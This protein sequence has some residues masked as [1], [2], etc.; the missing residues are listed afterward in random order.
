MRAD[1]GQSLFKGETEVITSKSYYI[2]ALVLSALSERPVRLFGENDSNDV[3]ATISAIQTLGAKVKKT[4]NGYIVIPVKDW[5]ET[6][7]ISVGESATLLRVLT[8]VLAAKGVTAEVFADGSLKTRPVNSLIRPLSDHGI[9][10]TRKTFPIS[11]SGRLTAGRYVITD[12]TTSGV[13]SGLITALPILDGDSAIVADINSFNKGYID[14]TLSAVTDFG[15]AITTT[16]T[17]IG[18][19]GKTQYGVDEYVVEKDWSNGAVWLVAGALSGNVTVRGLNLSSA[20]Y[21][22]MIVEYLSAMGAEISMQSGGITVRKSSLLPI[23]R[24]MKRNLDIVP[25]LAVAC[26]AADGISVLKNIERLTLKESDRITEIMRLLAAL[27]VKTEYKDGDLT[28]YGGYMAAN[29]AYVA[30][31]DHRIVMA[32][33]IAGAVTGLTVDGVEAVNKS[34]PQFFDDYMRLGGDVTICQ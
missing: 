21:D 9:V 28:V 32:A 24:D 26:A 18:I 17:G 6:V 5:P 4:R 22:R 34:Y 3:T 15:A 13:I 31:K 16:K 33:A 11:F 1:I 25:A 10:F 19:K 27:S 7:S 14:I 30:P 2:R 23:T 20:Q 12:T 8:P 29:S